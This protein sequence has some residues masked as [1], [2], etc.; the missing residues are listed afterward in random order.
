MAA[1]TASTDGAKPS[2]I[3]PGRPNNLTEEQEEKLKQMWKLLFRLFNVGTLA[4]ANG[5]APA[6]P[7]AS[8][9][10]DKADQSKKKSRFGFLSRK[11]NEDIPEN[12]LSPGAQAVADTIGSSNDAANDKFGQSKQFREALAQETPE[13]MRSAFWTMAKHDHPD[14]ILLRFLRARKWDVN[15]ALIMSISAQ[16]WRAKEYKVDQDIMVRGEEGALLDSEGKEEGA[17]DSKKKTDGKDFIQQYRMGKSYLH[18]FDKEGRPISVVR[19]RLH[20]GGEQTNDALERYTVHLIETGRLL[21]RDNVD[22]STIVFDMT[23]FTLANMDYTPVKFMIKCFEANYP[24]SLGTILIHRSP[25]IFQGIWKIIKPWLDPVVAAKVHFTSNNS[26]FSQF[27][28]P[29]NAP[30]ELGGEEEWTYKYI[31]PQAGENDKKKDA[32]TRAK[33]QEERDAIVKEYETATLAWIDGDKS[34]AGKRN[35][36]AATLS[37]NYWK[38][39]PYVRARTLYDRLG[40]LGPEGKL[41]F[42]PERTPPVSEKKSEESEPKDS[43][44]ETKPD[45]VDIPKDTTVET[46]ADGVDPNEK[47]VDAAKG[48][49][50]PLPATAAS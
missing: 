13:N 6:S 34:Q 7:T 31:E 50:V 5:D 46:T 19:V 43:G 48:N 38:I 45:V 42:Y 26:D 36:L 39:D 33:I 2:N 17:N 28:D 35:E 37:K 25:W 18:G 47:A 27:V 44:V 16:H 29:K 20:R 3:P 8:A 11:K 41:N 30:K 4:E 24:E 21:L 1:V 40:V 49:V 22:T 10:A 23:D 14:G 15:A 9:S 32:E 12:P